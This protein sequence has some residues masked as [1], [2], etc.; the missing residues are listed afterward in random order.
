MFFVAKFVVAIIFLFEFDTK[1]LIAEESRTD[2]AE[3]KFQKS[4]FSSCLYQFQPP[5]KKKPMSSPLSG[6]TQVSKTSGEQNCS[7]LFYLK[8]INLD[9]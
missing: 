2:N 5:F 1:Q 6:Y 8:A 4:R 7:P 3:S 9:N